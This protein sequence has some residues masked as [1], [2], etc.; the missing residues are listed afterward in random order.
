M[1]VLCVQHRYMSGDNM[2]GGLMKGLVG[3]EFSSTQP[4]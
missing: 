1:S 4:I 2:R 3:E